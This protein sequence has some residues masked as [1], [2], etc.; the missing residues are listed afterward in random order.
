M[1]EVSV[2]PRVPPRPLPAA[3]AL[4][5]AVRAG[6]A[7]LGLPRVVHGVLRLQAVPHAPHRLPRLHAPRRGRGARRGAVGGGGAAAKVPQPGTAA[8]SVLHGFFL[9]RTFV[10]VHACSRP[11]TPLPPPPTCPPCVLPKL[12]RPRAP[13]P[14]RHVPAHAPTRA[15]SAHPVLD[16]GPAPARRAPRLTH[17]WSPACGRAWPGAVAWRGVTWR[18]VAWRGVAWR[19]RWRTFP[20]TATRSTP[21]D[22]W[23]TCLSSVAAGSR[24]GGTSKSR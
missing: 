9:G 11:R 14:A 24:F 16:C 21:T 15:R 13:A 1:S 6:H 2:A 3:R 10:R 7:R 12:L 23:R 8:R 18:G 20:T 4:Q 5:Q 19:G 17:G 22:G